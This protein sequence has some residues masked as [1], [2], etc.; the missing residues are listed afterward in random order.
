MHRL[1]PGLPGMEPAVRELR[2]HLLHLDPWAVKRMEQEEVENLLCHAI[3]RSQL[4]SPDGP[5]QA[6]Q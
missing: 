1:F 3:D 4:V 5:L 2:H 6:A